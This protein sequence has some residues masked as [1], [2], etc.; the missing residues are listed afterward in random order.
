MRK[1]N[2]FYIISSIVLFVFATFYDF[3]ISSSLLNQNSIFG[4]IM[5]G[6]GIWPAI[7]GLMVYSFYI[8]KVVNYLGYV[9][10]II[11]YF[12]SIYFAMH[13]G[14]NLNPYLVGI[15]NI[16]I[17]IIPAYLF[18]IKYKDVEDFDEKIL[19]VFLIVVLQ[20][21]VITIIKNL[22]LRP[23]MRLLMSS[24]YKFLPWYQRG[25]ILNGLSDID[26]ILSFPSGHTASAA[27]ILSFFFFNNSKKNQIICVIWIIL[28][29][30][31]RIIVGAHFLSDVVM[32]SFI[33]F[34][35]V[36]LIKFYFD[37]AD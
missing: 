6:Y 15:I 25:I 36:N 28:V 29:A 31:S 37:R 8:N 19:A 13:N 21:I 30:L 9:V 7:I 5:A 33:C 22:W 20:Y 23:R 14:V 4:V 2:L 26:L 18:F 16:F 32:G 1:F 17:Y 10:L 24:D 11:L 27:T 12:I 35:I 3:Q 34:I